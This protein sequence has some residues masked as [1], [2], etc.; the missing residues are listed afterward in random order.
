MSKLV[1]TCLNTFRKERKE[2]ILKSASI[3]QFYAY[4]KDRISPLSNDIGSLC[5]NNDQFVTN[6]YDK[7]ELFNTFFRSVF[8][9]N[10]SVAPEFMR[11]TEIT[12]NKLIFTSNEVQAALLTFKNSSS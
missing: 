8:T 3:K 10:D 2:R 7:A 12:M 1:R 9:I 11:H 4:S 6:D 5:D